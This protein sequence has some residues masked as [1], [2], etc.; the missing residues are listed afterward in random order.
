MAA[1]RWIWLTQTVAREAQEAYIV[2]G[3]LA[4]FRFMSQNRRKTTA[5][6]IDK[7]LNTLSR[8][9]YCDASDGEVSSSKTASSNIKVTQSPTSSLVCHPRS[10]WKSFDCYTNNTVYFGHLLDSW[11]NSWDP[12]NPS[13]FNTMC[14]FSLFNNPILAQHIYL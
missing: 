6:A 12:P 14:Y 7:P 10:S 13:C 5:I 11:L 3:T 9:F 2:P 1:G 8:K 4:L